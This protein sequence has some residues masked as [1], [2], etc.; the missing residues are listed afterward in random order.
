VGDVVTYYYDSSPNKE[1]PQNPTI[2]RVRTD[3]SW[4]DVL[5]NAAKERQYLN[6]K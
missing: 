5:R 6:G 3:L 1:T 4:E 2:Y